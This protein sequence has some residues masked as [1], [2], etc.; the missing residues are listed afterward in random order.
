M[1]QS[2]AAIYAVPFAFDQFTIFTNSFEKS[3]SNDLIANKSNIYANVKTLV[4]K[5]MFLK[6][7]ESFKKVELVNLFINR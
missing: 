6:S 2:F 5:K 4:F 1:S 7:N 3:I